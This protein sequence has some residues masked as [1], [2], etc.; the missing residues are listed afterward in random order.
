MTKTLRR[1]GAELEAI[2]NLM[3]RWSERHARGILGDLVGGDVE[4]R[5]HIRSEQR[6]RSVSLGVWL[7]GR[8]RQGFDLPEAEHLCRRIYYKFDGIPM[9]LR[10]QLSRDTLAPL[11][12]ELV[13]LGWIRPAGGVE[14]SARD[15]QHW[16][17]L[18]T[19]DY[20]RTG[21]VYDVVL[22]E[23]AFAR[24]LPH[25]VQAQAQAQP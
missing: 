18:L 24:L 13:R 22:G 21:P 25:T 1:R 23:A 10:A 12:A 17:N 16:R 4:H 15:P 20:R 3:K 6:A 11:F 14:Q 2:L 8:C 7:Q 19:P 9:A 5:E